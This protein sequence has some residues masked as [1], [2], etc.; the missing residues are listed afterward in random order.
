[1]D[2]GRRVRAAALE[3]FAERG[4]HGTGIRDLAQRAGLST[5]TLYH[6]MGTKEELL[7]EIMRTSMDLL[8]QAATRVGVDGGAVERVTRLVHVH[9]LAHAAR[10][11]HTR[12]VDDE[13]R[14][15]SVPLR[16]EI[17][18]LRDRYER[19]WQAA[20]AAGV[21]D[22]VFH[23]RA[24]DVARRALLEMCSGVARWYHPEGSLAVE[25][26]AARYAELA[27]NLLGVSGPAPDLDMAIAR[28]A[29]RLVAELWPE[30]AG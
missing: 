3:L 18:A 25:E 27:L 28:D 2:A 6:Y 8:L 12:V 10:P 5:A 16:A 23:L 4:F 1:M 14:A 15:L 24:P 13:L 26:M 22:G 30:P 7:A 19:L 21:A 9:V 20:I 29:H 17:I 11:L